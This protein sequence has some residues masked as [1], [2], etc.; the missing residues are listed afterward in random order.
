M[1]ASETKTAKQ[2]RADGDT[3]LVELKDICVSFGGIH[4]VDHVSVDL[5]P[6]EVVGLRPARF[7]YY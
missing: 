6:G 2:R 7:R 3:P 5:H 4:A 1:T